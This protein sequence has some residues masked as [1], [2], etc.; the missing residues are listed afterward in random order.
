MVID[1]PVIVENGINGEHLVFN[2]SCHSVE[3]AANVASAAQSGEGFLFDNRDG[4]KCQGNI[5]FR[6]KHCVSRA[7]GQEEPSPEYP[8]HSQ[9][10]T[11]RTGVMDI[12]DCSSVYYIILRAHP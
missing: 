7:I 2:Q 11:S 12:G 5:G 6:P 9:N 1:G 3:E 10:W 8:T 4:P